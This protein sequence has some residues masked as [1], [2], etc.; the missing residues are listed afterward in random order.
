MPPCIS[1][2]AGHLCR[3]DDRMHVTS[4]CHNALTPWA[5]VAW[6]AGA[7][8]FTP[9]LPLFPH[10]PK[11]TQHIAGHAVAVA[12]AH[13]HAHARTRTHTHARTHTHTHTPR[14][15]HMR[16]GGRTDGGVRFIGRTDGGGRFIGRTD[17]GACPTSLSHTSLAR[18]SPQNSKNSPHPSV[19]I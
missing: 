9:L 17:G 16:E 13:T 11:L 6:G 8:G 1:V 3:H 14:C 15:G 5:R 12:D 7:L 2:G 4:P 10:A 19:G 18:H